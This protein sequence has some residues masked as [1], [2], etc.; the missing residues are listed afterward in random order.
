MKKI[1]SQTIEIGGKVD[2]IGIDE[3]DNIYIIM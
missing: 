3:D 1:N 2:E